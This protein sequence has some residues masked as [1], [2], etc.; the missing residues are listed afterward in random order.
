MNL[1]GNWN[2][3]SNA[4][5]YSFSNSRD[6]KLGNRTTIVQEEK[7]KLDLLKECFENMYEFIIYFIMFFTILPIFT[8]Y[9]IYRIGFR[10][11]IKLFKRIDRECKK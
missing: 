1:G 5:V 6:V 3:G 2:N 4:G 8:I 7:T 9:I 11:T 10:K